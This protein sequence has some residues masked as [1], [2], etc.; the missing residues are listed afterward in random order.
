MALHTFD[1]LIPGSPWI[2][3]E[4]VVVYFGFGFIKRKEVPPI[5]KD[6]HVAVTFKTIC[7]PFSVITVVT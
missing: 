4:R 2:P 5:K 6:T 1:L 7:N 3:E